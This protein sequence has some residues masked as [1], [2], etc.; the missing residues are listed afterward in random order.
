MGPEGECMSNSY[1]VG[2]Y[3]SGVLLETCIDKGI[4]RPR[5]RPLEVFLKDIRVE[6]PRKLREDNPLGTRFRALVK[7]S[8][9][10]DKAT[11]APRGKI[12][13]VAKPTTIE[14]EADYSPMRQIYAIPMG[15]RLYD[16]VEETVDTRESAL[17]TL[18]KSAYEAAVDTV[19]T[20]ETKAIN[21]NRN[22]TIRSYAI[23]RS[24][25][26]CEACGDPAPFT[27]KNGHPYLEIH[28]LVPV[29]EGGADHPLNV[30]AVCPNCHRRTEKSEDRREFNEGLRKRI[31]EIENR[32]G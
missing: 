1:E 13:L 25:G 26:I 4:S 6:F 12:Y 24:K 23:E 17:E 16:Y 18:R 20:Y 30:A 19:K 8:Q 21:R 27:T 22:K 29:S 5:V 3:F 7:V 11:G 2:D 10:T 9:K 28:H 14:L 32:L 31:N 15:D